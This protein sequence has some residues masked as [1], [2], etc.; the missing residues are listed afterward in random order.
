MGAR[1]GT[2]YGIAG[3]IDAVGVPLL[4]LLAE[5]T[6]LRSDLS[7]ALSGL[8]PDFLPGRDRGQALTDIVVALI[9][10]MVYVEGTTRIPYADTSAPTA[11][12]AITEIDAQTLETIGG[13]PGLTVR[14]DLEAPGRP[15]PSPHLQT[16]HLRPSLTAGHLQQRRGRV[17]HLRV[18]NAGSNTIRDHIA[19][20]T[21]IP[22]KHCK[23]VIFRSDDAGATKGLLEWIVDRC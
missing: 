9:L 23:R 19:V 15:A 17:A 2:D 12:R 13:R 8:R 18:G 11:W 4:R 1:T 21:Q 22:A 5:Q 10:G 3:L 6:G 14:S 20:L 16:T 7:Q